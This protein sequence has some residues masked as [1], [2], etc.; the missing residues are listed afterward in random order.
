MVYGIIYYYYL[1][2][3]LQ[4]LTSP[5]RDRTQPLAVKILGLNHWTARE[6]P[7]CYYYYYYYYYCY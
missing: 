6:F 3:S 1:P 7:V 5:T 2:H 4:D